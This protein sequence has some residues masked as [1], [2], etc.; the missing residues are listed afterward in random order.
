MLVH[1]TIQ[2]IIANTEVLP[3][4]PQ[5]TLHFSASCAINSIYTFCTAFIMNIRLY[6][7]CF[8]VLSV[9]FNIILLCK[10]GLFETV[11]SRF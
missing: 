1:E 6:S 11:V 5:E 9:P 2:E 7:G 10:S 3:K 8:V 4:L